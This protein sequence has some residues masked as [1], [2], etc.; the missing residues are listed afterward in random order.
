MRNLFAFIAAGCCFLII[1]FGYFNNASLPVIMVRGLSAYAVL[2]FIG[3]LI[4]R[5]G[6]ETKAVLPDE[7]PVS[8]PDVFFQKHD[9]AEARTFDQKIKDPEKMAKTIKRMMK[10]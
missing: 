5:A 8:L 2:L 7:K 1:L 10:K 4:L 9:P 3:N 6:K